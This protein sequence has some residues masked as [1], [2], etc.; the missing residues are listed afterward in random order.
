M[1]PSRPRVRHLKNAARGEG[2]MLY[3]AI[4][5]LD[6]TSIIAVSGA[7]NYI[8]VTT[9]AYQLNV[10]SYLK[11]ALF[12]RKFAINKLYLKAALLKY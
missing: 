3:T 1:S 6:K 2:V 5:A 4:R 12:S 11:Y 10:P 9:D 8:C 7:V